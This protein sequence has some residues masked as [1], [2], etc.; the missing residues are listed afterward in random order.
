MKNKILRLNTLFLIPFF[1]MVDPTFFVVYLISFGLTRKRHELLA[2]Y[3]YYLR[4]E[5][6]SIFLVKILALPFVIPFSGIYFRLESI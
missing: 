5:I 3:D 1:V 2:H 6:A 4:P